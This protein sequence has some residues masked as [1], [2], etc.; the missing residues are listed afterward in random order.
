MKKVAVILFFALMSLFFSFP[1]FAYVIGD[2]NSDNRVDLTE[3]INALQVTSGVR[4]AGI[5]CC[6]SG[7]GDACAN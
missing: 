5:M 2:V 1:G 3:A 7:T 4:T 6:S